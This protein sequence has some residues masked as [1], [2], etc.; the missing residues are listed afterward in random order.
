MRALKLATLLAGCAFVFSGCGPDEVINSKDLQTIRAD[1]G[2]S[3]VYAFDATEG[4]AGVTITVVDRD[5]VQTTATT[6][7]DGL[8]FIP[9]LFPG[10]YGILF[11]LTGYDFQV[12][13]NRLGDL[14]VELDF[15]MELMIRF[16]GKPGTER[17][18][19]VHGPQA[20]LDREVD[21]YLA[22]HHYEL[23]HR[24]KKC[25][26]CSYYQIVDLVGKGLLRPIVD[27]VLPMSEVR[28]AHEA[29]AKREQ[30][31]KIVLVPGAKT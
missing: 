12:A 4:L 15:A 23:T 27:R 21:E 16:D 13:F 8:W 31:G 11:E 6:T 26:R 2:G 18:S 22:D 3:V 20:E 17:V 9:N 7:A 24:L 10:S 29:M 25:T 14:R 28:A 5:G 30:F 1:V 19:L